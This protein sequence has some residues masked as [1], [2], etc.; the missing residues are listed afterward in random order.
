MRIRN[1]LAAAILATASLPAA[2]GDINN[3]GGLTQ[4]QF[5]RFT[6]DLGSALS[7]KALSPAE[8]LGLF[9]FDIGLAATDTQVKNKDVFQAVGAGNDVSSI[10]VPQLRANLGL[11]FGIDVGAMAA[12][13]PGTNVRLYGGEVKWAFI[14]GSTVMPAIALRGTYTKLAGV[15][16]LDL[17]TRGV[18]LSISKGFAM[19]T[20]YGGIGKVWTTSTPKNIPAPATPPSQESISQNRYF[21]GLNINILLVNLVLEADKTGDD[22]TYGVKLGFRF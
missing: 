5:H 7:Y 15:D 16:Q 6:Q 20:P 17:N 8:P 12:E 22:T 19:F 9:G 11:P 21:A 14:S 10:V 2:A 18:D 1:G 3:I 13:A 4:D